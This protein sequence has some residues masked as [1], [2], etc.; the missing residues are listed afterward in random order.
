MQKWKIDQKL[1]SSK[2]AAYIII[3]P[4][5]DPGLFFI[6]FTNECEQISN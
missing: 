3:F 4:S 2:W 1:Y 5:A 6:Y